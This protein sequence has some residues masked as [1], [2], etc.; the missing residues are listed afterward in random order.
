[1]SRD[2][3]ADRTATGV[4]AFD[5]L[6]AGPVPPAF[7]ATTVNVYEVPLVRPF[8]VHEVA[9]VVQVR[10]SGCDVAV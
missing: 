2:Q 3:Q 5:T 10:S 4:T 6:E 7:F 1:V 8:T 9:D